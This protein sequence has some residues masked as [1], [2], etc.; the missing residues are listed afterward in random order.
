MQPKD[1]LDASFGNMQEM[2]GIQQKAGEIDSIK[3]DVT[4]W[5]LSA[6]F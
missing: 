3:A 6:E 2:E 1:G 5:G 4:N